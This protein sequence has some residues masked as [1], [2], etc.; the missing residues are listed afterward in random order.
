ML[1]GVVSR[2]ISIS[3]SKEYLFLSEAIIFDNCLFDKLVGVHHQ[4]Y[5][6]FNISLSFL[7]MQESFK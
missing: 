5:I 4:K 7:G 3:F 1:F 6:E 2:V